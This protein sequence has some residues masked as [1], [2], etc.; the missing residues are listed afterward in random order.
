MLVM[1]WT[2]DKD[3]RLTATFTRSPNIRPL[4]IKVS[5]AKQRRAH[6]AAPARPK[7]TR[8]PSLGRLIWL[9]IKPW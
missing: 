1:R 2:L 3:G 9:T 6:T 8:T 7:P 4:A 5:P